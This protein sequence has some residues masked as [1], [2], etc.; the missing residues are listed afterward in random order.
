MPSYDSVHYDPPAPLAQ[1]TLRDQISGNS[2]TDVFLLIDTG[3][4]ITLL[5][6]VVVERLGIKPQAGL[7]YEVIGFDGTKSTA[8]AVDLDVIFLQ[9][10]FRGKYLLIDD[11][12]GILGRDVLAGVS[13]LLDGPELEWFEHRVSRPAKGPE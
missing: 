13:L 12:R 10:A 7:S 6:R 1:V 9:K 2:I 3:A 8:Q 4:D 5:P 11:E